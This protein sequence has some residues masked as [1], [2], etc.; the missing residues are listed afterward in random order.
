[1]GL[2]AA[3]EAAVSGGA[4]VARAAERLAQRIRAEVAPEVLA[5]FATTLSAVGRGGTGGAGPN[6][7]ET[8]AQLEAALV[9][10][11]RRVALVCAADLRAAARVITRLD[12]SLPRLQTVGRIDDLDEFIAATPPVRALAE[13]AVTASF[14]ALLG[15]P[16]GGAMG[17]GPG[18]PPA[19]H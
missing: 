8:G 18:G 12:E 4:E 10:T 2:A 1:V 15:P 16:A 5:S 19:T 7:L 6:W 3:A 17:G 9:A 11:A 14:G 13:F